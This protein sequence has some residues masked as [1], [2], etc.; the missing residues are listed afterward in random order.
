MVAREL[1]E[2][3]QRM[4]FS[5]GGEPTDG[6]EEIPPWILHLSFLVRET[7]P[8]LSLSFLTRNCFSTFCPLT[9]GNCGWFKSI[10]TDIYNI[11]KMSV[12]IGVFF[13]DTALM[14]C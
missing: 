11:C 9:P 4:N 5:G 6:E 12:E 2:K 1:L 7:D 3:F 10:S 14:K 13:P 8:N